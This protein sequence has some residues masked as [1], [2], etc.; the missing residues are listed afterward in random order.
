MEMYNKENP[1]RSLY[2]AITGEIQNREPPLAL[3]TSARKG[4]WRQELVPDK[5]YFTAVLENHIL[6]KTQSAVL[7]IEAAGDDCLLR[8]CCPLTPEEYTRL[9]GLDYV[10]VLRSKIYLSV[11]LS[12]D[13]PPYAWASVKLSA[14]SGVMDVLEALRVLVRELE[15]LLGELGA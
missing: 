9:A 4:R 7:A 6:D 15:R 10:P 13:D 11:G 12:D 2:E 3:R 14:R 1:V 8:L 5:R